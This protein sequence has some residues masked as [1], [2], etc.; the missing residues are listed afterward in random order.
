MSA[1][2]PC[3]G[4]A[5][6]AG[7]GRAP[8]PPP[9]SATTTTTAPRNAVIARAKVKARRGAGSGSRDASAERSGDSKGDA[10]RQQQREQP[11]EQQR[12]RPA[13]GGFGKAGG[14]STLAR[15]PAT[16]G[17]KLQQQRAAQAAAAAEAEEDAALM[18]ED[19]LP[20]Y[21][22]Y[23][24]RTFKAPRFVTPSLRVA[25]LDDEER[26]REAEAAAAVERAV[27]GGANTTTKPP[28]FSPAPLVKA[29]ARAALMPGELLASASGPLLYAEGDAFG[30]AGDA[31]S[32]APLPPPT[33]RGDLADAALEALAAGP[34]GTPGAMGAGARCA[35]AVLDRALCGGEDGQG[36]SASLAVEPLPL[37]ASLGGSA[38]SSS[39]PSSE[40]ADDALLSHEFAVA[41]DADP[42]THPATFGALD[43]RRWNS[44]LAARERLGR[45]GGGDSSRL[46]PPPPRR[47]LQALLARGGW[48]DDFHDPGASQLRRE[49][50]GPFAGLWPELALLRHSCAPNVSAVALRGGRLFLHAARTVDAGA[51]ATFGGRLGRDVGAPLSVRARRSRELFGGGKPCA[52]ARCAAEA[53]LPAALRARIEALHAAAVPATGDDDGGAA[54]AAEDEA[55]AAELLSLSFPPPSAGE[56]AARHD[57]ALAAGDADALRELAEEVDVALEE[58]EDALTRVLGGGEEGEQQPGAAASAAAASAQAAARETGVPAIDLLA[59][60]AFDAYDLSWRLEDLLSA[61]DAAQDPASRQGERGDEAEAEAARKLSRAVALAAATAPGGEAHVAL[62]AR[63]DEMGE[64]TASRVLAEAAAR[65]ARGRGA[66]AGAGGRRLSGG[67]GAGGVLDRRAARRADAAREA[68]EQATLGW[69]GA[70][71]A[72]YGVVSAEGMLPALRRG[73]ALFYEGLARMA[74]EEEEEEEGELGGGGAVGGIES[75]SLGEVP[76]DEGQEEGMGEAEAVE[77]QVP[78]ASLGLGPGARSLGEVDG[79]PVVVVD[80]ARGGGGGGGGAGAGGRGRATATRLADG[81]GLRIEAVQAAVAPAAAAA[82]DDDGDLEL[83]EDDDE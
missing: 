11:R 51:E 39:S 3:I 41:V 24:R 75:F 36:G 19:T 62:A 53:S 18:G 17:G 43:P 33:V 42:S 64:A 30:G 59:A 27:G 56:W 79:I 16:T 81:R 83:L 35:L 28:P 1:F 14:A 4:R 73:Q 20:I 8:A 60:G 23:L 50:P 82:A 69:Y 71:F 40:A 67:N 9:L 76:D 66:G 32:A 54:A 49:A 13:S 65:A 47:R 46:P 31:S 58:L 45:G 44:A 70:A 25:A 15:A 57:M 34:P 7:T 52:C 55:A 21:R 80:S 68:A 2:L 38:P 78:L 72:R 12:R 6:A 61:A 10:Q 48:Q 74:A 77:L 5:G 22:A 26:A 29:V 63:L 37:P